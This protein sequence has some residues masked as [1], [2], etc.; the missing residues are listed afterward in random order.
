MKMN[1]DLSTL[2]SP[3]EGNEQGTHCLHEFIISF[4]LLIFWIIWQS[5]YFVSPSMNICVCKP[6]NFHIFCGKFNYH[7][8]QWDK[9]SILL[10]V[11]NGI[12]DG[13]Q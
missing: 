1:Y 8:S 6:E 3:R 4:L 12:G 2:N 9:R 10:N 7:N 11:S 5:K 13:A